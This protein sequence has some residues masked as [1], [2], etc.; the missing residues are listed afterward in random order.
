MLAALAVARHDRR[1]EVNHAIRRVRVAPRVWDWVSWLLLLLISELKII[2]RVSGFE[3]P[4]FL[5]TCRESTDEVGD[6]IFGTK[7]GAASGLGGSVSSGKTTRCLFSL[8]LR[9]SSLTK[10]LFHL[11][12]P[13]ELQ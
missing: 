9:S 7:S 8:L 5:A 3:R 6:A 1:S 4:F 10:F 11:V 2:I 12:A 13:A